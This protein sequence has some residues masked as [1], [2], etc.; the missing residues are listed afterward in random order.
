M[1]PYQPRQRDRAMTRVYCHAPQ[2]VNKY[3][4]STLTLRNNPPCRF[5]PTVK[6]SFPQV[7]GL[8]R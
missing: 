6:I 4:N 7:H 5:E 8:F 3:R 1:L 2:V